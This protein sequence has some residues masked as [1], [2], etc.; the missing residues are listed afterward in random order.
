MP[1]VS[2]FECINRF[3]VAVSNDTRIQSNNVEAN[4]CF[5]CISCVRGEVSYGRNRFSQD[6]SQDVSQ[7]MWQTRA[8]HQSNKNYECDDYIFEFEND[9]IFVLATE[10]SEKTTIELDDALEENLHDGSREDDQW[11]DN[12]YQMRQK[13]ENSCYI[14]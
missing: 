13:T 4:F 6:T 2:F 12:Q 3:N 7:E 8:A 9:Y 5:Q 10:V 14:G 1:D 11:T